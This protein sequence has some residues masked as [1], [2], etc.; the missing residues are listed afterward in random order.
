MVVTFLM[1]E[2]PRFPKLVLAMGELATFDVTTALLQKPL[3]HACASQIWLVTDL[4]LV[5][6]EG[7]ILPPCAFALQEK[8]AHL[9]LHQLYTWLVVIL[10]RTRVIGWH[11]AKA[12]GWGCRKSECP[13]PCASIRRGTQWRVN[14]RARLCHTGH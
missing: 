8:S 6:R 5:M 7:A 2:L 14:M 1:C 9:C 12:P 4:V 13:M 11:R 3:T 10:P